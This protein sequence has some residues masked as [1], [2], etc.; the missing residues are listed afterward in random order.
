M[1]NNVV[2]SVFNS[3]VKKDISCMRFNFRGA[4]NSTGNHTSGK[5]ELSDVKSC[6]D[7]LTESLY[8]DRVFICGYS[9]GAAIGCSAINHSEKIIGYCAISFPWDFISVKYKELSQS[10][11]PKLFIQGDMD[12]V[13][14]YENFMIHFNYYSEPKKF[15][16]IKGADH[17]YQGFEIAISR[18][19]M[20]FY[21]SIMT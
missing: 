13:A 15:K 5:G 2:S 14:P 3:F 1:Y 16:I 19:V 17:F 12:T 18:I 9:Y 7:Y 10:I 4:G 8:F 21:E 6:I 11:K 20:N